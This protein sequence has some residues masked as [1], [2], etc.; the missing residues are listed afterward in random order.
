MSSEAPIQRLIIA[1]LNCIPGVGVWRQNTGAV[2]TEGGFV[3]FGIPGQ[4]DVTGAVRRPDGIAQRL[5]IECKAPGKKPSAVQRGFRERM[6]EIGAL[7][8]VAYEL[9]DALIPVVRALG[10]EP[11]GCVLSPEGPRCW[12]WQP[13]A[14]SE[15]LCAHHA[16]RAAAR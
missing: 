3:R 2:E 16:R 13:P 10:R 8:I 11:T 15:G 7:H 12:C 9:D 5:E 4:A 14:T 1:R 6:I